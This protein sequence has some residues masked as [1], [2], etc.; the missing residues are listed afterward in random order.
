MSLINRKAQF[1]LPIFDEKG[2]V[3]NKNSEVIEGTIVDKVLVTYPNPNSTADAP[4]QYDI[5]IVEKA[6][7]EVV[8]LNPSYMTKLLKE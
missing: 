2:Q 6:D 5:Y 8:P 4:L 1:T 7:G 3:D